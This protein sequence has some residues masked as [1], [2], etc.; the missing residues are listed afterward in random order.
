MGLGSQ[1]G[2]TARVTDLLTSLTGFGAYAL[3]SQASARLALDAAMT[4]IA[5]L[6]TTRGVIG[7][8]LSRLATA[9]SLLTSQ[10]LQRQGALTRIRDADIAGE[11]ARLVAA[12]VQQSAASA[13]LAQATQ[14]PAL[15]L[16]ILRA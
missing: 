14:Q 9:E 16:Q 6:A 15:A 8:S 3:T 13:V 1:G 12:Q 4:N 7:A 2:I 11:S 5:E 10:V